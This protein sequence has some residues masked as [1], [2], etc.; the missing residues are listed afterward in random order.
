MR[1]WLEVFLIVIPDKSTSRNLLC[2]GEEKSSVVPVCGMKTTCHSVLKKEV[3]LINVMLEV[4][5]LPKEVPLPGF[6]SSL[7]LEIGILVGL[8]SA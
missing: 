6:T 7:P 8:F 1:A 4:L 3:T 5:K 2:E